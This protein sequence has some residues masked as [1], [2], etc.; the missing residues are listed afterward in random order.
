MEYYLETWASLVQRLLIKS[1]MRWLKKKKSTFL[2][3]VKLDG[4]GTFSY[5]KKKNHQGGVDS[6]VESF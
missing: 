4:K 5:E 1:S 3:H 2:S 6:E